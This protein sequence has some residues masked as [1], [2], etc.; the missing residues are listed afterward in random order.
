MRI[1]RCDDRKKIN[2]KKIMGFLIIDLAVLNS[3]SNSAHCSIYNERRTCLFTVVNFNLTDFN[4]CSKVSIMTCRPCLNIQKFAPPITQLFMM[5][6]LCNYKNNVGHFHS[7][8]LIFFSCSSKRCNWLGEWDFT[9]L[10]NHTNKVIREINNMY[11]NS[12]T[13]WD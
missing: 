12:P 7:S 3:L 8:I 9:I 10:N 11:Q 13:I 5:L 1:C 4:L 2:F 6:H